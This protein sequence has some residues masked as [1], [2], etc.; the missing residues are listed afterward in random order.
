MKILNPKAHGVIDYI[1]VAVLAL[2]PTLFEFSR[3]P[4]MLSY[5]AAVALLLLSLS[6]AYPLGVLKLVPFTWHR[7]VEIV[8]V[9]SLLAA[10]WLLR[11]SE[12]FAARNFFLVSGVLVGIVV[13][14]TNY[15]NSPSHVVGSGPHGTVHG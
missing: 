1:L 15:L 9:P 13:A 5:G 8:I 6:T 2:A 7:N 12:E 11:F 14:I 10:P 3:T 4:Q